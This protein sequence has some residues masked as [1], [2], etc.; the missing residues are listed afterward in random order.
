MSKAKVIVLAIAI[1]VLLVIVLQNSQSV[2]VSLLFV[3][4]TMPLAFLLTVMLVG[5]FVSG[6]LA[7]LLLRPSGTK[8]PQK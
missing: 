5:G 1:V 6:L 3:K 8:F 7:A 2:T 4:G